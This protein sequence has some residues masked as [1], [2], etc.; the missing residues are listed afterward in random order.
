M[1]PTP[2]RPPPPWI[3]KSTDIQVSCIKWHGSVNPEKLISKQG[4]ITA[5]LANSVPISAST[6]PKISP[7]CEGAFK[8]GTSKCRSPY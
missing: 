8:A 5:D 4:F 2:G 3:S 1:G 6:I 7:V